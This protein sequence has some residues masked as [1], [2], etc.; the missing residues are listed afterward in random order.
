MLLYEI[1]VSLLFKL[2]KAFIGTGVDKLSNDW[3]EEKDLLIK[4][5]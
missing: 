5:E 4:L 2:W 1:T 3:E